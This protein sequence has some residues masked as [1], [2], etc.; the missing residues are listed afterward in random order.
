MHMI[1]SYYVPELKRDLQNDGFHKYEGKV[2]C[3]SV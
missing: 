2:F 3:I 1:M